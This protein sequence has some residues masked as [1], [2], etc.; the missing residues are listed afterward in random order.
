MKCFSSTGD[1]DEPMGGDHN[2]CILLVLYKKGK[3]M[4]KNSIIETRN[5]K[6]LVTKKP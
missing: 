1:Y 2:K 3:S 4:V 5:N 6:T